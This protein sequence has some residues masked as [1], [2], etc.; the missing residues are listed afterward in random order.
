MAKIFDFKTVLPKTE[1]PVPVPGIMYELIN[2]EIGAEKI[3][4]TLIDIE[5]GFEIEAHIHYHKKKEQ[6]YI[7]LEGN[8]TVVVNGTKHHVKPNTV[9]F[10]SPGDEHGII[11]GGENGCKILEVFS[12]LEPNGFV[13]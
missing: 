3:G 12:P 11:S 13:E 10:L 5:P 1:F 4:V 6:A 2:K 7:V 8:A 9:I